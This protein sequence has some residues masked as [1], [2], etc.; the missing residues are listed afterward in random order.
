LVVPEDSEGYCQAFLSSDDQLVEF[1]F[2]YGFAVIRDVLSPEKV[3]TSVQ[4]VWKILKSKGA[5]PDPKTWLNAKWKEIYETGYNLRRGFLG[6]DQAVSTDAFHNIQSPAMHEAYAKVFNQQ[7]L[8]AKMDRYGVM[9]PT[10]GIIS[11]EEKIDKPDWKTESNWI[12]WDQNP[13]DEPDF[14]RIQGLLAL[15]NHTKESGGFH[16]IPGFPAHFNKWAELNKIKRA[17]GCLVDFP[18]KDPARN[19]IQKIT[20]RPGSVL[21][22]DSRLP[23][24]NWPNNSSEWRMVQYTGLFPVPDDERFHDIRRVPPRPLLPCGSLW[25]GAAQPFPQSLDQL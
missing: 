19:G 17:S 8:W 9:R 10:K 23:H 6:F 21:M 1:F 15:T 18:D 3:Q 11:G 16:C 22:W 25:V 14:C 7:N 13:W 20:M 12:H 24:G 2:K 5:D 4:E